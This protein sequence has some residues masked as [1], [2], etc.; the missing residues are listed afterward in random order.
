MNAARKHVAAFEGKTHFHVCRNKCVRALGGV[1]RNNTAVRFGAEFC[2]AHQL[3]PK[4]QTRCGKKVVLL[5]RV[6]EHDRKLE[7]HN[8]ETSLV[9]VNVHVLFVIVLTVVEREFRHEAKILGEHRNLDDKTC[10]GVPACTPAFGIGAEERV[11]TALH[12]SAYKHGLRKPFLTLPAD[13]GSRC[14]LRLVSRVCTCI[15]FVVRKFAIVSSVIRTARFRLRY[16]GFIG[17]A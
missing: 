11:K 2:V 16:G 9:R 12:A 15:L 17:I 8:V 14:R 5:E 1:P 3:K 13:F 7:Q 4:V 10:A 6:T